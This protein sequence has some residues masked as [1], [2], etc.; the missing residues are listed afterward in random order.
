M[1]LL[2]FIGVDVSTKLDVVAKADDEV[3]VLSIIKTYSYF[4]FAFSV[5]PKKVELLKILKVM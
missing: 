5:M 3:Y 2:V 1:S 4:S